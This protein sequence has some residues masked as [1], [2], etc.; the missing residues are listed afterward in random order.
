MSLIEFN[1]VSFSYPNGFLAVDQVSFTI[2]SGENVAIVGQNGAGKTTTV[3]MINGLIKPTSGKVYVNGKDT[4]DYTTAT[5]SREAGYVFQNP[6]DQIFHNTVRKEIEYG[7]RMLGFDEEKVQDLTQ[8]AAHLARVEDYLE[9]NPY[10]LP[11]SVRKFVTIASVLAMDTE[12]LI[13]DEPT[14]GQDVAGLETLQHLLQQLQAMGKTAI[15]ITHDMDFVKTNF[16]KIFV[17][18]NKKLLRQVSPKALFQDR[19]LLEQAM[20]TQPFIMQLA[21]EI[22]LEDDILTIEDFV[23]AFSKNY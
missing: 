15:T 23:H 7:P 21:E 20:L 17:M 10:N 19:Q 13:F 2:E 9:E 8:Q 12:I 6:D 11:L 22:G 18:A 3:K 4:A 5:L 14:A 1:D 16:K